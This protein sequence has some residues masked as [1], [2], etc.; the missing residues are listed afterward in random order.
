MQPYYGYPPP[1]PPPR[2]SNAVLIVACVL[3]GIA[4][5]LAIGIPFAMGFAKGLRH[6]SAPPAHAPPSAAL[7]ET[8]STKNGLLTAHYPSDFVAKN[9]DSTTL[10]IARNFPDGSDEEVVL[11]A[12]AHPITDDVHEFARV[13]T[14]SIA[15]KTSA[16]GSTFVETT[17]RDVAC[18]GGYDG[19]NVEATF[20]AGGKTLYRVSLCFFMHDDRGYEVEYILPDART[21]TELPLLQS[22]AVATD[23]AE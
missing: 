8:Y 13:L 7:S 5:L 19:V 12:V 4:L 18:F 3:G 15:K 21:A 6:A 11:A 9:V 22:I 20:L 16:I 23:Y 17:H 10:G 2:K 14:A 1:P